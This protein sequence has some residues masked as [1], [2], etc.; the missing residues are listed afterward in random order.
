MPYYK[1]IVYIENEDKYRRF[2]IKEPRHTA[3]AVW[4]RIAHYELR[5]YE[6]HRYHNQMRYEFGETGASFGFFVYEV[7][8]CKYNTSRARSKIISTNG[9]FLS[10]T[11]RNVTSRL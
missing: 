3:A 8:V 7:H 11:Q 4:N 5:Q 1:V 9:R 2:E 6:K 10:I